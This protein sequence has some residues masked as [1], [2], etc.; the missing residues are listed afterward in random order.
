MTKHL[1]IPV[2]LNKAENTTAVLLD[3]GAMGNFIHERLVEEL[4][5]VHLPRQL[6]PLL[7]VKGLTI[8]SLAFQVKV[9]V[10]IGSHEEQLV[11]DVA[12][13]GS[14]W[15]ILGLPWL[16]AH[17]PMIKWSTSHIQFTSPHC[18]AHCLP[19]PHDIFTKINYVTLNG[20]DTGIP[21]TKLSPDACN[22]IAIFPLFFS[23]FSILLRPAASTTLCSTTN[24]QSTN[25]SIFCQL[26][27]CIALFSSA[28][29]TDVTS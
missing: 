3:L 24:P 4:G 21:V 29:L 25:F 15:L 13:I 12:P 18:N 22:D 27:L 2:H 8:G 1:S 10:R 16:Q 23:F 7:D 17:D 6:L 20:M 11:L 28:V 9:D 5:L 26:L 19:Q 14:H